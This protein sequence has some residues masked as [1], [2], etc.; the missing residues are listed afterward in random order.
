[1]EDVLERQ[2]FAIRAIVLTLGM[3]SL[4]GCESIYFSAMEKV[5]VHKRD[6]FKDR[7][8]EARDAQQESK[9]QFVSALD[10][11]KKVLQVEETSLEKRYKVL[12][13]EYD[14]SE[15]AAQQVRDKIDAVESVSEALFEEWEEELE[16]YQS[17]S[18][19][20]SSQAKLRSTRRQYK[21]L[22]TAMKKVSAKMD[23]VLATLRDQT[24]YL[25]H[26]LN[27]QSVTAVKAELG[28]IE[29]EVARLVKVME[30]S[31]NKADAFVKELN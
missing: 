19:K 30:V 8:E 28:S 21:Q 3:F 9:E 25:K 27:A 14:D 17:G 20:R 4:T 24:L 15:A 10:E 31:I 12:Q 2:M 11:F 22:M 1:M 13:S 5:G 23:P 7:I 6:I 29:R 16:L 18:L 26:N